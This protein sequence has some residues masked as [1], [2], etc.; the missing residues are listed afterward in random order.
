MTETEGSAVVLLHLDG[1]KYGKNSVLNSMEGNSYSEGVSL[2]P[3]IFL[4]YTAKS[5]PISECNKTLK[6]TQWRINVSLIY[7]DANVE[8]IKKTI[9]KRLQISPVPLNQLKKS[10]FV[11]IVVSKMNHLTDK[12]PKCKSPYIV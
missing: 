9:E 8:E 2:T 4:N 6:I 5:E 12:C 11:E 1:E 3:L 7:K 10:Q